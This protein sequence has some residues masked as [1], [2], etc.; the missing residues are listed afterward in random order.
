MTEAHAGSC[1]CGGVRYTAAGPL[2]SI[3]ACHCSQ[4]RKTSGH[5]AAMTAVPK[6]NLSLDS[7]ETL[8]WFESSDI[9]KR[10]FCGRCGSN[11]FWLPAH[12]D[13]VSITAGTLDGATGLT[14]DRHIHTHS[15]GDYYEPPKD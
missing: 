6:E 1:L 4:C 13:H 14:L 10:G 11:L 8:V 3:V 7:D 9:A 15:A 2:R 5:H 12:K